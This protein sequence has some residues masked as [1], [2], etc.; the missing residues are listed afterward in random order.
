MTRPP[1]RPRLSFPEFDHRLG[2]YV[3][4]A[5]AA[6]VT[7]LALA[8]PAEGKIIYTKTNRSINPNGTLRIDLNHDGI[9]DFVL[10]DPLST[11]T[12]GGAFNRLSAGPAQAR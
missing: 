1:S 4:A 6:G 5:S 9:A 10:K 2:M 11:S 7:V 8:R 12:A 3:L